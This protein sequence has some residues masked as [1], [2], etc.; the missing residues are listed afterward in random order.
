MIYSFIS[1]KLCPWNVHRLMQSASLLRQPEDP[2]PNPSDLRD[3]GHLVVF[4]SVKLHVNTLFHNKMK[5]PAQIRLLYQDHVKRVGKSS[6]SYWRTLLDKETGEI[7]A[8]SLNTWVYIDRSTRRPTELPVWFRRSFNARVPAEVQPPLDSIPEKPVNTFTHSRVVAPSDTD[9]YAHVNQASYVMYAFD[10]A[11]HACEEGFF[12]SFKGNL[13]D[14]STK[15][16]NCL[17]MKEAKVG[18]VLNV[19][20]WSPDGFS[21][22]TGRIFAQVQNQKAQQCFNIDFSFYPL[23]VTSKY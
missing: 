8:G 12:P 22:A 11:W 1:E 23:S 16:Q 17:Y 4:I 3:D 20:V 2:F 19:D 7:M 10:A 9:I 6:F 21:G 13:H 18:E 15:D 5:R 14:Y